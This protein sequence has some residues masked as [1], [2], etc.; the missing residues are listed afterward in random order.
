MPYILETPESKTGSTVF[1]L[2]HCHKSMG[3]TYIEESPNVSCHELRKTTPHRLHPSLPSVHRNSFFFGTSGAHSRN[4]ERARIQLLS[5]HIKGH[6]D[7]HLLNTG[8]QQ[9]VDFLFSDILSDNPFHSSSQ[10]KTAQQTS[11]QLMTMSK[12]IGD[13][14]LNI[15]FGN[16]S[17]TKD[18]NG[19]TTKVTGGVELQ[20]KKRPAASLDPELTGIEKG[21]DEDISPSQGVNE[22]S[23]S[24]Q[25]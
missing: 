14:N 2:N 12:N 16:D 24:S 10:V 1:K 22:D 7:R 9:S 4:W 15:S 11:K 21:V 17:E 25:V 13:L 5:D 3:T 6:V 19:I 18:D 20:N 8:S 23:S